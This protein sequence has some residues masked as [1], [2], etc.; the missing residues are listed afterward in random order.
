MDLAALFETIRAFAAALAPGD[1]PTF[2]HVDLASGKHF[3][4]PI[5]P[6]AGAAR[7]GVDFRTF[8]VRDAEYAFTP[9]QAAV[10]KRLWEAWEEDTPDVGSDTLLEACGTTGGR[11]RDVFKGNAAWG[12]L[13]LPGVARGTFRLAL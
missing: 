7:H 12:S 4:L 6:A 5:P 3:D 1:V 10:V 9:T 8:N 11:L 13:I 2:V